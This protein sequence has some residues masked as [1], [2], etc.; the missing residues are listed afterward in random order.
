M[1]T[2]LF[3]YLWDKGANFLSKFQQQEDEA[4]VRPVNVGPNED[5]ID[6]MH[7]ASGKATNLYQ[8]FKDPNLDVDICETEDAIQIVQLDGIPNVIKTQRGIMIVFTAKDDF[9]G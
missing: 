5:S 7:L 6:A 8:H 3:K 4:P 2:V 1:D 9:K